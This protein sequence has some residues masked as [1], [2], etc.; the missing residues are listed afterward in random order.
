M[1][2]IGDCKG[3]KIPLN[4]GKLGLS[5]YCNAHFMFRSYKSADISR[6][7]N[8]GHSDVRALRQQHIN[9]V[10]ISTSDIENVSTSRKLMHYAVGYFVHVNKYSPIETPRNV[11]F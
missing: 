11:K 2:H 3:V 7:I 6:D 8:H 4:S 5:A 9:D 1:N 10:P